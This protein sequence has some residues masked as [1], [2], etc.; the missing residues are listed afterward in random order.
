MKNVNGQPTKEAARSP[1]PTLSSAVDVPNLKN[2]AAI[3]E[4]L[5]LQR[6][7]IGGN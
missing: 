6:K 2:V 7:P 5:K 3:K 4:R 1:Q